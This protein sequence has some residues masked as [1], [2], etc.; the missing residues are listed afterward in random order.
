MS[1]NL[2]EL[3]G[4]VEDIEICHALRTCPEGRELLPELVSAHLVDSSKS[5]IRRCGSEAFVLDEVLEDVGVREADIVDAMDK[6]LAVLRH[7]VPECA[8][9]LLH[10]PEHVAFCHAGLG[11]IP[12]I[13]HVM[14]SIA[15]VSIG[16]GSKE[17]FCTFKE[18]IV[19]LRT[20]LHAPVIRQVSEL[21][22]CIRRLL[23]YCRI[24]C[25]E[26]P[27]LQVDIGND[28]DMHGSL[29]SAKRME[30]I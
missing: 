17:G 14:V 20:S 2:E 10:M 27:G 28:K 13:R 26:H 16:M 29:L 6:C 12:E 7:L 18:G 25:I 22:D 1:D 30:R 9:A 21:H 19:C 8:G 4:A 11:R 24:S 23:I 5:I 15:P 3:L